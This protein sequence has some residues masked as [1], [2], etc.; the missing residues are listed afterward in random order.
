MAG[1]NFFLFL[2][3]YAKDDIKMAG[4]VFS[5]SREGTKVNNVRI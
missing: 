2:G 4:N 3:K 5:C 1:K